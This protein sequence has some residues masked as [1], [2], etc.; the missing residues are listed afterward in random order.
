MLKYIFILSAFTLLIFQSCDEDSFSQVV[1]IDIPEHESK[2]VIKL[3]LEANNDRSLSVLVSN[4]KGLLDPESDYKVPSDAIVQLYKNGEL[5]SQL[6]YNA[7]VAQYTDSNFDP[8]SDIAGDTYLLE[9]KLEGYDK[10]SATQ[11]MPPKPI[12]T[13]ATYEIEGT[14]DSEGYR[15][16]Q[17]ITDIADTDLDETNYYGIRVFHVDYQVDFNGDTTGISKQRIYL[18]SNDPLLTYGN[19]YGLIFTDEAFTNGTFQVR[20]YS[21]NSAGEETDIEV[22]LLQLSKDAYFYE[23]SF[24]QYYNAIDNPFAEPVTV[25]NN[26]EGGYGI[27]SLANS[28]IF[29]IK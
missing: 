8:I 4:S 25:H 16:D 27:F 26:I 17:I 6:S 9:A 7:Q 24:E 20:A 11:K 5:L 29:K 12:I 18:D 14:I 23:R 13:N 10:V 15:A 21:Y 2:P 3:Q 22:E 1:V 19:R 28:T